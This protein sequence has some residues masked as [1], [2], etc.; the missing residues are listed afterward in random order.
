MHAHNPSSQE[1]VVGELLWV[2]GQPGYIL[3]S[4][5]AWTTYLS[6][7]TK[8]TEFLRLLLP[9]HSIEGKKNKVTAKKK[10]AGYTTN[11]PYI[12][13]S[14]LLKESTLFHTVWLLLGFNGGIW[15]YR[16]NRKFLV[17]RP[18]WVGFSN[19]NCKDFCSLKYFY[20]GYFCNNAIKA[21]KDYRS[22]SFFSKR[23]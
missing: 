8:K 22:V 5:A 21:V 19:L 9:K 14:S 18:D 7:K 23:K 20:N 15:K 4:K 3:S 11:I 1:A 12:L 13:N 10:D 16:L 6:Q 17:K 2:G